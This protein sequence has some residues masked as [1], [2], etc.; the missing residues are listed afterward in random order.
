MSGVP[1][2]ELVGE[3]PEGVR[4]VAEE[5]AAIVAYICDAYKGGKEIWSRYAIVAPRVLRQ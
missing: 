1:G 3:R 5:E 4:R 2:R